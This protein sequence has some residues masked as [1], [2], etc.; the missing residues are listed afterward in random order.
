[1][2]SCEGLSSCSGEEEKE[3]KRGCRPKGHSNLDIPFAVREVCS[4]GGTFLAPYSPEAP[5]P[6]LQWDPKLDLQ[7]AQLLRCHAW[8]GPGVLHRGK[9][10]HNPSWTP[11]GEFLV[12]QGFRHPFSPFPFF[13]LLSPLSSLS[14]FILREY[15]LSPDHSESFQ[16][17]SHLPSGPVA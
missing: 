3:S 11:L 15:A 14:S 10:G 2:D 16:I 7:A 1:M 9:A 13:A 12:A 4:S 8:P 5:I 6:L 17:C